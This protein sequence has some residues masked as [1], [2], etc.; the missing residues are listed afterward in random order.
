MQIL[1]SF[2][3]A[4]LGQF[5]AM[6]VFRFLNKKHSDEESEDSEND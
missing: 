4:L 5:L 1:G 2:L 3:G 6:L